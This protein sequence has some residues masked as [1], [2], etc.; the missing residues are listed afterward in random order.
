MPTFLIFKNKKVVHS[1]RGANV[2][3]LTNGIQSFASEVAAASEDNSGTSPSAAGDS[4]SNW[5][6]GSI[7]KG[8]EDVSDQIDI[9]GID[10]LNCNNEVAPGRVLFEASK[11]SGFAAPGREKGKAKADQITPDLVE[12]DTD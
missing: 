11:P 10:L 7:P 1:I 4:S 5:L 3:D 9:K 2:Q 12:S 6:G 8:Y